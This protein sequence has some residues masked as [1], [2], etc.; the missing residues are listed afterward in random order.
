MYVVCTTKTGNFYWQKEIMVLE[1]KFFTQTSPRTPCRSSH[2]CT[3][4]QGTG[5]Q[6][7]RGRGVQG[8]TLPVPSPYIGYNLTSRHRN[9]VKIGIWM[10]YNVVHL[11]K[12]NEVAISIFDQVKENLEKKMKK[13][14]NSKNNLL[15]LPPLL[16]PL[17]PLPPSVLKFVI[18]RKVPHMYK[19][20]SCQ[21]SSA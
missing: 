16:P 10:L 5:V 17:L 18:N 3:G 14:K 6:G 15:P 21:F 7:Y 20:Q 9:G 19:L 4:V 2:T 8:P 12:K 13:M 1:Q 11:Q